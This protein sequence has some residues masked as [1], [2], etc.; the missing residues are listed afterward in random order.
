MLRSFSYVCPQL[1]LLLPFWM[2]QTEYIVI[3]K[4]WISSRSIKWFSKGTSEQYVYFVLIVLFQIGGRAGATPFCGD[5]IFAISDF[6]RSW[7]GIVGAQ[8]VWRS[9][10]RETSNISHTLVG[11]QILDHSDVVGASTVDAAPTTSSF[12][13]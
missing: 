13:T 1:L 6:G 4:Y 2:T 9:T 3:L 12:S 8:V 11:N 7:M 10:C 5:T